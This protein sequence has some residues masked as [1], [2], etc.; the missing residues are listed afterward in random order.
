MYSFIVVLQPRN[1]VYN[2]A[3]VKAQ[4]ERFAWSRAC[5]T[6]IEE[7]GLAFTLL[8]TQPEIVNTFFFVFSCQRV[9]MPSAYV[10]YTVYFIHKAC[11]AQG[12][13]TTQKKLRKTRDEAYISIRHIYVWASTYIRCLLPLC[14]P[15]SLPHHP[16]F[17][18][19]SS[20]KNI[21]FISQYLY[22]TPSSF[23]LPSSRIHAKSKRRFITLLLTPHMP[24]AF[25]YE[26]WDSQNPIISLTHIFGPDGRLSRERI[27]CFHGILELWVRARWN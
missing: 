5:K 25:I 22:H 14:S 8:H 23:F 16:P 21:S 24:R 27:V 7:K 12:I 9:S 18:I 1:T 15:H 13:D 6:H 2:F 3:S 17:N 11:T 19:W 26:K 4:Q 10:K 20:M